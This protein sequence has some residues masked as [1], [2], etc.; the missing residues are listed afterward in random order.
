MYRQTRITVGRIVGVCLLLLSVFGTPAQAQLNVGDNTSMTLNGNLA[1]GYTGQFGDTGSQLHSLYGAGDGLLS[2]S[3]YNPN[4]LSFNVRPFYNR[5]Q[6]NSSFASVLS[7]TGVDAAVNLFGGSRFPGAV[8]FS[9]SFAN[10][11]QYGIPGAVGLTSDSSTRNFSVSWSELLP[12]LPSLTATFTDNSNS[13][14]IQGERGTTSTSGR[15]FN[16]ISR[17]KIDGFGLNGY[18]NHQN[19]DVT[20]PVFLSPTN[21]ESISSGTSYGISVNH[22]LPLQGQFIANYSRTDYSS[23]AGTWRNSG[24]TD[25]ADVLA[26]FHPFQRFSING[27]VRYTGNLYG[28]LQQSQLPNGIPP[29]PTNEQTSHGVS[30]NSYGTY[31]LGRGFI[32]VGYVNH[33]MQTFAGQ[34]LNITRAGGTLTYS[35]ARP[36]FGILY[37]SFGMANNATNSNGSNLGFVGNVI[38]KKQL[39]PWQVESDFS[40]SQNAQTVVA[41][42]TS[43]N[44]GYGGR[45]RRR[46]GANSTWAISYHGIQAGLTQLPGYSNRAD[47]FITL[48]NR[49]RYGFSASY[50]KSRGTA[51]L[52]STGILTPTALAPVIS[53]DQALYNGTVY[54]VGGNVI[55]LRRMIINVNWYRTRSDTQT[56]SVFSANNS[57]RYY[58]QLQYN[59]RK[60]TFRA[61][62][63][64]VYQTLSADGRPP[65]TV[66][67]YYFNISRWFSVF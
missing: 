55:P 42:Y 18:V 22:A 33:S 10:G 60:L 17:Y 40:Y 67:T 25:T 45:V 1:F 62:Y 59:L 61:G 36:L 23:E 63:W 43:S 24:S 52:S 12:N 47:T 65:T 7:E 31:N 14:T 6:D 32:L 13:A 8:S 66:N 4:F 20:L 2:G 28:A 29:V 56:T 38:L 41:Y 57:E 11:S 37:F 35:Y 49:G 9:K 51:L 53:P 46:F 16:L 5:N 44:Y 54:G 30:L 27:E 3:Y 19:F 50:S 15:T 64:R 39:G 21:S 34:E 58:G 26:S 48:L